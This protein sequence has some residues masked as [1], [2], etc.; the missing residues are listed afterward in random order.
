MKLRLLLFV[1]G[2]SFVFG[3]TQPQ[4]EHPD[5]AAMQAGLLD[6]ARTY[7]ES[8]PA[9]RGAEG[10]E[11]NT[12]ASGTILPLWSSGAVVPLDGIS[13]VDVAAVFERYYGVVVRSQGEYHLQPLYPRLSILCDEESGAKGAFLKFYLPAVDVTGG[14]AVMAQRIADAA[15]GRPFSGIV[16]CASLSGFPLAV[17]WYI[18][19]NLRDAAWLGDQRYTCEQNWE[20]MHALGGY[21]R[22]LSSGTPPTRAQGPDPNPINGGDIDEVVILPPLPRPYVVPDLDEFL[23][24]WFADDENG[25]IGG[26]D[27]GGNNGGNDSPSD[28]SDD[29][30]NPNLLT[31]DP[32]VI[33]KLDSILLDCMGRKLIGS[34]DRPIQIRTVPGDKARYHR[35]APGTVVIDEYI[36]F[37]EHAPLVA[38]MEDLVHAYQN[39]D[40]YGSNDHTLNDEIEAKIGWSLY[41]RKNGGNLDHYKKILV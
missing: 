20:R 19:G 4:E 3:C 30:P 11:Y 31:D 28:D 23:K 35:N 24:K 2:A 10:D 5:E 41:I 26:G 40:V 17:V 25:G 39:R 36:E 1:F 13:E 22:I 9:T 6:D 21:F 12:L 38:L 18:D 14:S 29:S 32:V 27:G 16:F 8:L 37:G 33:E 7:F 34:F 15:A